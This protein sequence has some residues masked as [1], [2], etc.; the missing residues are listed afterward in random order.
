MTPEG[1]ESAL[2]Q[3]ACRPAPFRFPEETLIVAPGWKDTAGAVAATRERASR[4]PL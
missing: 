1:I 2:S 3:I 4:A